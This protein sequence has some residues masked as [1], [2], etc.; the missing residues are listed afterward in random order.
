MYRFLE[1]ILLSN[2]VYNAFLI[3]MCAFAA[4][5]FIVLSLLYDGDPLFW[6]NIVAASVFAV[7]FGGALL[8]TKKEVT[9]HIFV[10]LTI[11]IIVIASLIGLNIFLSTLNIEGDAWIFFR[12]VGMQML[13]FLTAVILFYLLNKKIFGSFRT[14]LLTAIATFAPAVVF[15]LYILLFA[16]LVQTDDGSFLTCFVWKVNLPH[17]VGVAVFMVYGYIV[18]IISTFPPKNGDTTTLMQF[19]ASLRR[20][21]ASGTS[22]VLNSPE[23]QV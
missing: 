13:L 21:P 12:S 10:R 8:C 20:R 18:C 6:V 17:F 4:G 3:L 23:N 22:F 1:Q 2:A 5:L 7:F 14:F 9:M 15:G 16:P 19:I 11:S